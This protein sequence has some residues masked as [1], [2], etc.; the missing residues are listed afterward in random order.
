MSVEFVKKAVPLQPESVI[1]FGCFGLIT[2]C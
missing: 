1:G 2:D